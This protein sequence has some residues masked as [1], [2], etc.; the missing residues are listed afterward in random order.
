[1]IVIFFVTSL[2]N[3]VYIYPLFTHIRYSSFLNKIKRST[4]Y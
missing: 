3:L 2:Y 1:M 4:S